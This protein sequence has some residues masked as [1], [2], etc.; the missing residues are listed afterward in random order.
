MQKWRKRELRECIRNYYVYFFFQDAAQKYCKHVVLHLD[1]PMF[2]NN[3]LAPRFLPSLRSNVHELIINNGN[4]MR[5]PADA[6][7]NQYLASLRLITFY[8]LAIRTWTTDSFVGLTRL[9]KFIMKDCIL[10][11]PPR[12]PLRAVDDTLITLSI[13]NCEQWDPARITG[14]TTFSSLIVVDFSSNSFGDVL[15]RSSFTG[16]QNC[17]ALYLNS[18]KISAIGTGAFDSLKSIEILYLHNNY[19]IEISDNLFTNLF[20]LV[21]PKPRINLQNNLWHCDCSDENLRELIR[22]DVLLTDPYCG[23]PDNFKHLTFSQFESH[24]AANEPEPTK[25][26]KPAVP[27]T[28][29]QFNLEIER[30]DDS[31]GFVYVSS[32]TCYNGNSTDFSYNNLIKMISPI[33][34]NKC[35]SQDKRF[36]DL[37]SIVYFRELELD[38]FDVDNSWIKFTYLIKTANYSMLQIGTVDTEDYGM[39]WYQSTCPNEIYCVSHVPQTLRIYNADPEASYIFCPIGLNA[40]RVNYN[41]CVYHEVN[42]KSHNYGQQLKVLAYLSTALVCLVC[43]ALCVYAVILKYP[44]L[45]K[46]SKRI[47]LVKHKKVDALVLPPKVPIRKETIKKPVP[48]TIVKEDKIFVIPATHF[49]PRNSNR[50]SMRSMKSNAPSYI[51]A[52]LP[53][54]D[55]LAE[56]RIRHHFNNDLSITSTHSEISILSWNDSEDTTYSIDC[57]NEIIYESLK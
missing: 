27:H 25:M 47:L 34:G 45:L 13:T 3:S 46:G 8:N 32:G 18:C 51:S 30:P 10:V 16:L 37:A 6:F 24:C 50:R 15:G 31:H 39:V 5:I 41:K 36:N 19:L 55:Q 33:Y 12:D 17:K 49:I 7:M 42:E 2:V 26:V 14:A 44:S 40:G 1:N 29:M 56:W 57:D 43:G 53:T 4:L 28:P 20:A 22:Q 38:T 35:F 48:E 11:N 9:L 21:N 52:L 54:E 23:N